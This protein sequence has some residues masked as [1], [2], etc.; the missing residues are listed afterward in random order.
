MK[1]R[2]LVPLKHLTQDAPASRRTKRIAPR[3]P[4]RQTRPCR[5]RPVQPAETREV[6]ADMVVEWEGDFCTTAHSS[7]TA[8]AWQTGVADRRGRQAWQTGVAD[9]RGN[10][11]GGSTKSSP[12]QG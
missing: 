11:R 7:A 3:R 8:Q 1:Y 2:S 9:R 6:G 12:I 4:R 5:S 10:A